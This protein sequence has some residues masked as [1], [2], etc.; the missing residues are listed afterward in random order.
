MQA[1]KRHLLQVQKLLQITMPIV[2]K[3]LEKIGLVF[4]ERPSSIYEFWDENNQYNIIYENTDDSSKLGWITLSSSLTKIK[5]VQLDREL[6]IFG[7]AI[8]KDGYLY[9]VYGQDDQTTTNSSS[10]NFAT[11]VTIEVVKY[12]RDGKIVSK[13][14]IQ[15]RDTSRM[16]KIN[17]NPLFVEYGTK[18]PFKFGNCDIAINGDVMKCVYARK[19]YNGHQS[20]QALY[21][22]I[23]KMTLLNA[24]SESDYNNSDGYYFINNEYWVSHSMAQ[25]VIATSDGQ[26]MT[27]DRGD[28]APRAF[29]IAKSYINSNGKRYLTSHEMFHF[30]ES[31]DEEFGYNSTLSNL[32]NIVELSDGYMLI[33]SS[34][35]TLSLNYAQNRYVNEAQNMF[36]QKY[37]KDSW[38]K[39]TSEKDMQML[40][41]AERKSETSRT[42]TKNKGSLFLSSTGETD[43][44]VKWMTN[45]NNTTVLGTR[46]VKINDTKLALFWA[47]KD[48]ETKSNGKLDTTGNMRYFYEIIDNNGNIL[49]GPYQIQKGALSSCIQYNY[50]DGYIY[51]TETDKSDNKKM[52]IHKLDINK[53]AEKVELKISETNKNITDAD[54]SSFKI[55]ATTNATTGI[56]WKSSNISVA[57]VDANGLVTIKGNG[58][59]VITASLNGYD[60]NEKCTLNVDYKCKKIEA[61]A[62]KVTLAKDEM[63][64]PYIKVKVTPDNAKVKKLNWVSSNSNIVEVV[65]SSTSY[66]T[67]RAK[68]IGNATLTATTTDGSNLTLKIDINVINPITGLNAKAK[69]ITLNN[70]ETK[71]SGITSTPA[72]ATEKIKYT[73]SNTNVAIV[74]QNGLVTAKSPGT[75]IITGSTEYNGLEISVIVKVGTPLISISLNKTSETLLVGS[76]T[77]LKVS[78]NPENTSDSKNIIWSTTNSNVA[79]VDANGLVTAKSAGTATITAETNDSKKTATCKIIVKEA[80]IAIT[81]VTLNK[82]NITMEPGNQSTLIATISPN[83]TTQ[84]KTIIWSSSNT[85]IATISSTGIVTA[86]GAGTA[87]ITAKTTNGLTATCKIVVNAKIIPI[88]GVK[89]NIDALAINN[90]D[91]YDK[92]T[93][94]IT[95]SNTTQSKTLMWSSSNTNIL[96]VNSTTGLL[97]AK[98][99]GTAVITVRTSN[100]LTARINVT[101]KENQVAITNVSLNK[102]NLNLKKGTTET[103][104]A[105][106]SP[107][108]TTQNKA[109]TW[110]SSN[111]NIAIVN[112]NGVVTAKN[113]GT[114][115]ISARTVNGK[116]A[117]CVVTVQ[118][119]STLVNPTPEKPVKKKVPNVLY[120]T[121]V[122]NIGWQ[123]YVENGK[124]AGT[125]G[126]SLR[127]E[128]CNIKL[129]NN[130]YGGGIRYQ[131]HIQNIGWQGW[132]KDAEM[133]G[134]S[135][136]SLRLEGIRIE[137]TGNI[138]NYY[139]IYYRVHC[140]NF[141]WMGWAKNG[142]SAG[143]AGYSYRLEGLEIVLV[144]KGERAPGTT[145]NH[146]IQK[147]VTYSTHVQNVGWQEKTYDGRMSGTSGKS[148]RLEGIQIGL[149]NQRYS[150]NIEYRTHIQN[151]GWEKSY[152]RN[153]QMSG[154]SGRSL[155]LEAIQIRLTGEMAKKYDVYYSVHC[156]NFGW[157]GWAKNGESAGS[158]GYSYRLEGIK[159]VLV[160]KG[161]SAPG[162]TAKS[163]ISK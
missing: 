158:A 61:E 41:T 52:T 70:G 47:E 104:V 140:Q 84:N 63:A 36:I 29:Y 86:K 89:I 24:S 152:K 46:A 161:H 105:I 38:N 147:Y 32:G 17:T 62:T 42:S 93:A 35:K 110:N 7:N 126:K 73:S 151:I 67:V 128:G 136:K 43:Y 72:D 56:T 3:H 37:K 9:V 27:A 55:T 129:A 108:N 33:A 155:R 139:D 15:A 4:Y 66:V 111:S 22:S 90:G 49:K 45:Y 12:G 18:E 81:K 156:Q 64:K 80:E 71:S 137:L 123:N 148:L 109:I 77:Q 163:F 65:S 54:I 114:A 119:V 154:T 40:N 23:S 76:T 10:S 16:D 39:S 160:E 13:L 120:R 30:R 107:S 74:D 124:M 121:H 159:I 146:F 149:D 162:S 92:L 79:R 132:K 106:I 34:E 127:L 83:N 112:S 68:E 100:G 1:N 50:K 145:N 99:A 48:L 103:L 59:A 14:P 26:F 95:P 133:S 96:E 21:V 125:S 157:M 153:N 131:T 91:Y 150:G 102:A 20:S 122:Q 144:K 8:Y 113:A 78:Y 141:G 116:I 94:T 88:T 143:S 51:W 28:G 57:T 82:T 25:R 115:V 85:N 19:M 142:E 117:T 58:S 130:E 87:T 31:S 60:I 97:K 118:N 69:T 75:A 101:V 134:T 98:S 11:T 135:G 5:E 53:T 2:M 6:E 138:A 44:G